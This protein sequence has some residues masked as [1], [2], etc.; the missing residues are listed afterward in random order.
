MLRLVAAVHACVNGY[1]ELAQVDQVH[2]R[3]YS[4]FCYD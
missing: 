3:S 4:H 1:R 2:W